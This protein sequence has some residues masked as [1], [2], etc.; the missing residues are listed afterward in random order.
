MCALSVCT[1][2]ACQKR[3]SDL[4]IDGYEP[5]MVLGIE[6]RTLKR[7]PVLLTPEPSLQHRMY[8]FQLNKDLI[9]PGSG[10]ARL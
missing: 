2:D 7:Q 3:A 1:E 4:V 9:E 10:G 6:L 5:H 8:N